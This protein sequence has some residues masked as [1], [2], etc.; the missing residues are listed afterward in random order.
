[1][2]FM[3]K[4][5]LLVVLFSIGY[6]EALKVLIQVLTGGQSHVNYAAAMVNALAE[7]GHTVLPIYFKDILVPLHNPRVIINKSM[8]Y[9]NFFLVEHAGSL[10]FH[11]VPYLTKR[12]DEAFHTKFDPAIT[13]STILLCEGASAIENTLNN[14]EL[15]ENLKTERYDVGLFAA[16]TACNVGIF[17]LIGIRSYHAYMPLA[18]DGVFQV[19]GVPVPASYLSGGSFSIMNKRSKMSFIERS[20][21]LLAHWKF[22]YYMHD[23]LEQET[24]L[25]R[26]YY[27]EFPPMVN[28]F[29]N[30][31]Y[32][33][34]NTEPL[35]S[36]PHPYS[37]KIK[38]IG[39]I[40]MREP[41][42]LTDEYNRL[43]NGS[44]SGVILFSFGTMLRIE[45]VPIESQLEIL[46]AFDEFPDHLFIWKHEKPKMIESYLKQNTTHVR[47]VPWMPQKDLLND[48]RV[49]MFISH[50][51]LNSYLEAVHASVPVVAVPLF[52]DQPTNAAAIVEKELGVVVQPKQLNRQT[53]SDAI[54]EVLQNNK[55]IQTE[56][57]RDVKK[58]EN[59]TV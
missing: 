37:E 12:F 36:I 27:P 58:T 3:L 23:L 10:P 42:T 50:V 25:F 18:T 56:H 6:I 26:R 17:H 35:L 55:L 1:M 41:Q 34:E 24:Q 7:R 48:S 46:E 5:F 33:F 14:H 57:A 52:A 39:G 49:K 4:Y 22:S 31:T 51:G 53:L 9:R 13:E 44:K 38:L 30:L 20:Q 11:K 45:Q 29:K 19:L 32:Y 47:L 16:I 8:N 15:M 54:R 43:L 40:G 2:R 28:V 21:S 59:Q